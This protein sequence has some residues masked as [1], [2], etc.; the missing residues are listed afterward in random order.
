MSRCEFIAGLVARIL[1]IEGTHPLRVGIDGV[2]AAGKTT[3][4]DELAPGI[5]AAGRQAIRAS[6]DRFHNPA[7]VRYQR[8]RESPEGYYRD[9]FDHEALF[10]C[11]LRPLGPG[12]TRRFRREAFDHRTDSSVDAPIEIGE[13]DA[14][15]LFDGIFLHR[16]ELLP[17]WDFSVFLDVDFSITVPRAERRDRTS[18]AD[19]VRRL[20]AARYVPAQRLYLASER[21]ATRASLVVDNT[22]PENPVVVGARQRDDVS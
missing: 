17:H 18:P 2:D 22:D 11:L 3:L 13:P 21:P 19:E 14:V 10:E 4:A 7:S 15:L 9:S 16:P 20:Y 1:A 5:E 8:G 6:I 12:G